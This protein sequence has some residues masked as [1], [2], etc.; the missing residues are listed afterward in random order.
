MANDVEGGLALAAW[1]AA[2]STLAELARMGVI[3]P[4]RAA[5]L[6]DNAMTVVERNI[7]PSQEPL[8]RCALQRL[9]G[10][11]TQLRNLPPAPGSVPPAPGP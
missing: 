6:M 5:E 1:L 7:Q 2:S 11:V 9:E 10:L 4:D 3:P 8:R